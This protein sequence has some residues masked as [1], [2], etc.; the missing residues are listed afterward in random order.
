MRK[1][2]IGSIIAAFASACGPQVDDE[3][4][5]PGDLVYEEPLERLYRLDRRVEVIYDAERDDGLT[6]KCGIL[7]D[8]AYEELESTLAALDPTV[9]YGYDPDVLDCDRSPALVHIDDFE[10]SPFECGFS[11]CH[12][13]LY[14]AAFVYTM[15]LNNF[16]GLI[17][18]IDGEPYVA[19]EPDQPCP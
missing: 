3:E 6:G 10:H 13:D 4:H 16:I 5:P 7:T 1:T 11:C 14:P 12:R 19:I 2:V 15:I 18:D 9:D 17:P 8:R